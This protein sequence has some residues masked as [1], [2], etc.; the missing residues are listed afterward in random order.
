MIDLSTTYLGLKLRNPLVASPSPLCEDIGNIRRMEDSGAGA[1]VMHSLFEEQIVL[2][3]QFLDRSLSDGAE[4]FAEAVSYFPDMTSY[5]L[6]PEKYLE[7]IRKAKQAVRIPVI[8]SLNGVSVGGW[9]E[10]ARYIEE[11]GADALELNIYYVAADPRANAAEVEQR[12]IDLVKSVR[13][14]VRIPI[15]VKIGPY[16]SS[17]G[18]FAKRLDEAGANGLVLFNRFY[19]PDFDLEELEIVP[20]LSLSSPHE[21]LV[22]LHWAALL[23][24]T[25]NA[26]I[27][28]TGGVYQGADLLKAMMAGARIAM[29]TASLLRYGIPHL[30]TVLDDATKWLEEHEYESI[31]QMQGS[32]SA[33]S[34]ADPSALERANY[35]KVISS[36]VL[37]AP[38]GR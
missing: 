19:Q 30:R 16:F 26:D 3:S 10:Y 13:G 29:T 36:Y 6:G 4:S 31:R 20:S 11:A 9:T 17:F 38:A 5:N 24:G 1:V 35:M 7:H 22:R 14:E 37:R 18:H 33:R 2:E 12:Y 8:G 23:Y 15:A 32:M 27:A 25:I 21:L 34:V 28:I